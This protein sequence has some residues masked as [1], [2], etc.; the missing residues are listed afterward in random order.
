MDG[1]FHLDDVIIQVTHCFLQAVVDKAQGSVVHYYEVH[2]SVA[3]V[4]SQFDGCFLLVVDVFLDNFFLS[5]GSKAFVFSLGPSAPN[6]L[7]PTYNRFLHQDL[8][9]PRS[10]HTGCRTVGSRKNSIVYGHGRRV[11]A[12]NC[13]YPFVHGNSIIVLGSF[14]WQIP[15]QRQRLQS[16]LLFSCFNGLS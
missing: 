12:G 15:M 13:H 9:C 7:L 3:V 10:I 16:S 2:R 11:I 5:F 6:K 8:R 1:L 4:W 14:C